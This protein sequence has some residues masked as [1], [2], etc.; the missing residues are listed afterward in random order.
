[1]NIP[2]FLRA[3][4]PRN[5]RDYIVS[6]LFLLSALVLVLTIFFLPNQPKY[7]AMES[8]LVSFGASGIAASLI[9][10]VNV[11]AQKLETTK[12]K[13]D[14]YSLFSSKV[15]GPEGAYAF[16]LASFSVSI[17]KRYSQEFD[18]ENKPR[19]LVINELT[20][21]DLSKADT[22][23]S[24]QADIIGFS[25][26]SVIFYRAGLNAPR[27]EWDINVLN[28]SYTS[29]KIVRL[30]VGIFSNS[31]SMKLDRD[32]EDESKFFALDRYEERDKRFT[33]SY[34]E[35]FEASQEYKN[36]IVS[37]IRYMYFNDRFGQEWQR[38]IVK[39]DKMQRKIVGD[40]ISDYGLL[41]KICD[42]DTRYLICGSV[43]ERGTEL[44][45]EYVANYWTYIR[46][47]L[48]RRKEIM[49]RRK[50]E[51]LREDDT[52][53]VLFRIPVSHEVK[54]GDSISVINECVTPPIL[55]DSRRYLFS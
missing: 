36:I 18:H 13:N 5:T 14:L 30:S 25:N 21:K 7:S 19:H 1:M 37:E 26:L 35:E 8:L 20:Q 28:S 49:S 50:G 38:I 12:I 43:T 42:G 10:I 52:Y 2:Y 23:A 40:D 9:E 16:V 51:K 32:F 24:V 17:N 45:T 47:I 29:S 55:V 41:A 44:L 15:D 54:T 48:C 22:K 31:L 27:I 6:S 46:K 4:L 53:A 33:E 34:K 39:W 11:A 3:F